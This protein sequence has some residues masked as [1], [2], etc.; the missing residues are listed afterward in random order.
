MR[1]TDKRNKAGDVCERFG[2]LLFPKT[3]RY[4]TR[5]LEWA[6]WQEK[7]YQGANHQGWMEERWIDEDRSE[8][9]N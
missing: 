5:W 3:I 4:E 6:T 7:Y 9:V 1:W 8:E 2:F